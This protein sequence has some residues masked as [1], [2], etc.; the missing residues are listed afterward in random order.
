MAAFDSIAHATSEIDA[1]NE[2][3]MHAGDE[4]AT[5]TSEA[6]AAQIRDEIKAAEEARAFAEEWLATRN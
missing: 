2:Y 5:C 4:L 1:I 6:T 3:L